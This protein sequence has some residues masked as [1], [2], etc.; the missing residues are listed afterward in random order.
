MEF[1]EEE[2][3]ADD[4]SSSSLSDD[5]DFEYEFDVCQVF[6]F[7]REETQSEAEEAESWFRFAK[8]YPPSRKLFFDSVLFCFFD[9]C[10]GLSFVL[11]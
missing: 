10:C 4:A 7:T 2:F 11:I 9:C 6:D 5:I 3:V 8:E 1:M